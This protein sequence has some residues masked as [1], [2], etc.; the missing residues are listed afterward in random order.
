MATAKDPNSSGPEKLRQAYHLAGEAAHD[1]ADNLK[2]RAKS[3]VDS[4]K[5]RAENVMHKAEDSIR[6]HPLMSV[7]GAFLVGWAISKL[8]K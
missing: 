5:E 6:K 8:M 4:N 1:A 3:S 7:G 2:A